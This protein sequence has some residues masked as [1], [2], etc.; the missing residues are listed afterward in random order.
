MNDIEIEVDRSPTTHKGDTRFEMVRPEP[1]YAIQRLPISQMMPL[2]N[3]L[4]QMPTNGETDGR[5]L[6][7]MESISEKSTPEQRARATGIKMMMGMGT[8]ALIVIVLAIA[9][10]DVVT[11]ASIEIVGCVIAFAIALWL[12]QRDSPLATERYKAKEY[13]K[14]R[15]AEIGSQERMFNRR[16]DALEKI[17][18]GVLNN[19]SSRKDS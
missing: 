5:A 16:M 15:A 19:A 10:W 11:L 3:D 8:S 12:D 1:Q 4:M 7:A 13:G 14:I 6:S 2:A 9:G 18:G 17:V